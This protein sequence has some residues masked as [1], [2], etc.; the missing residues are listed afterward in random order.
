MNIYDYLD[1]RKYIRD[2]IEKDGIGRRGYKTEL[3]T[4]AQC[5]KS[6]LSKLLSGEHTHLSLEQAM[7]LTEFWNFDEQ[8]TDFF[9]ELVLLARAG[10][11]ELEKKITKRLER[12]KKNRSDLAT[13]FNQGTLED[14]EKEKLYYSAWE[15]GAIHIATDCKGLQTIE[16]VAEHLGL[17]RE[18]VK[19]VLLQLKEWGMVDHDGSNWRLKTG[20]I[21]LPNSSPLLPQ[22]HLNW[23][24]KAAQKS[25]MRIPTNLHYS[26]VQ[27]HDAE[28]FEEIRQGLLKLIDSSRAALAKSPAESVYCLNIDLF[29]A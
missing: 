3:A 18:R 14:L 4:A 28:C 16:Q 11:R 13:R 17:S 29:E 21:H 8:E 6:Y 7:G 12:M 2:R 23:R 5:Q 20:S 15:W 10:S 1:Y 27:S 24:L 26:S 9:L 22:H 19:S 25:Q